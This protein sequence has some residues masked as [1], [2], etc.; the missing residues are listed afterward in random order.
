ME[1]IIQEDYK[2]LTALG[3]FYIRLI[4]Y[5]QDAY[6]SL[7]PLYQDY[8]K[9]RF[10]NIDGSFSI[11]HMDEYIDN[12]LNAEVYLDTLLPHILKRYNLEENNVLK[13]RISP[14]EELL[15][16]ELQ[17]EEKENLK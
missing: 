11:I 14:L 7:E 9:L 5:P 15:Q 8:R 10:R 17:K 2:Y 13:P 6:K 12:L 3:C 16:E 1:Y 4:G